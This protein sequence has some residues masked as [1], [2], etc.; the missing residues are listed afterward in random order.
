MRIG[1]DLGGSKIEAV[2]LT[3]EGRVLRRQRRA[4]PWELG[5]EAVVDA[6]GDLVAEL[7]REAPRDGA[8]RATVG[9]GIP[10]C[11]DRETGRVKN[12]NSTALIGRPLQSDLEA[13]LGCEVRMANDANCFAVAEALAGAARGQRMVFGVILGTGV[14]GGLVLDGAP[15]E[16]LH[17]IAGEWGHSPIGDEDPD[18]PPAPTCYCGQRG[19]VETRL[20]GPAFEADYARL[21]GRDLR[22]PEILE[23]AAAR[24]ATAVR[25]LDRYLRF[26]GEGVARIIHI[27]DPDAIVLGG[28]MSK[29]PALYDRGRDAVERVL[30]DARL[31]TPILRHELGDSAGVFGAAWLWG[32]RRLVA[33]EDSQ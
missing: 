5:Y 30:F 23:R 33:P 21:S 18:A 29:T 32:G 16:G 6:L 12:A 27:L 2:L 14:G 20:S 4:T 3:E 25:A 22:A 10:G 13:R 11:I 28:G 24:E 19:C 9:V 15:R 31:R 17:G 8:E 26:F 7:E 1:I